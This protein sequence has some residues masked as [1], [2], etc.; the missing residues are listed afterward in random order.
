MYLVQRNLHFFP[1][2]EYYMLASDSIMKSGICMAIPIYY[3]RSVLTFCVRILAARCRNDFLDL[4]D[5]MTIF[6]QSSIH[7]YCRAI[8]WS[9]L[10]GTFWSH[11]VYVQLLQVRCVLKQLYR[12]QDSQIEISFNPSVFTFHLCMNICVLNICFKKRSVN[13][14]EIYVS[15]SYQY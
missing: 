7:I 13:S 2:G 4:V 14:R 11:C 10:R 9:Q 6:I 3:L 5:L 12:W 15:L 8:A 1:P